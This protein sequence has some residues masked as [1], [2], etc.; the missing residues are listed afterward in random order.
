MS[1]ATAFLA[2]VLDRTA[3]LAKVDLLRDDEGG[4]SSPV[5]TIPHIM[6]VALRAKPPLH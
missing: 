4:A 2:L 5:H 6:S 3:K 1:R